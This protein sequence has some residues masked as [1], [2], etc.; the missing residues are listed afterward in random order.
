MVFCSDYYWKNGKPVGKQPIGAIHPDDRPYYKIVIDPYFK[1]ISV[2][3]YENHHWNSTVYDSLLLDF[4]K[5]NEREQLSW[6]KVVQFSDSE[7][8][9]CIIRDHDDRVICIEKHILSHTLPVECRLYS[10]LGA[11]LATQKISYQSKGDPFNGVTLFDATG[12]RVREKRYEWDLHSQ[13]FTNLLT[14][15]QDFSDGI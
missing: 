14:D 4:R 10:P 13:E 7:K 2:E 5:L 15:Q 9:E 3:Q 1:R 12:R 11:H 8:V 6:Q